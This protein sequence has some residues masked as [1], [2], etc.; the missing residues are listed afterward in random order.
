MGKSNLASGRWCPNLNPLSPI[1]VKIA[2]AL[3]S[4]VKR[5]DLFPFPMKNGYFVADDHGD[6]N[7]FRCTS[8]AED[9]I[10]RECESIVN[11]KIVRAPL[12]SYEATAVAI[13]EPVVPV[14]VRELGGFRAWR[15][16]AS[17]N[18]PFC[19]SRSDRMQRYVTSVC[20]SYGG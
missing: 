13:S 5:E 1:P 16:A 11:A 10:K 9:V 8:A 6:I 20:D 15:I 3:P 7:K 12:S 18:H 19:D 17:T 14:G 2:V 4:C